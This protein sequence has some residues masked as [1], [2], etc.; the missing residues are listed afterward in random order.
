MCVCERVCASLL[1]RHVAMHD[2][3]NAIFG[4]LLLFVVT[5]VFKCSYPFES[6]SSTCWQS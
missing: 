1:Q 3:A 2:L 5:H 4:H 6:S